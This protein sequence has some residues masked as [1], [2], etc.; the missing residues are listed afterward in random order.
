MKLDGKVALVTGAASGFGR[1]TSVLFAKEGAKVSVVDVNTAGGQE[2]VEMIKQSGGVAQFLSAD[3]S[4]ASDVEQMIKA[5]VDAYSRLDILVN[6]A[7][8]PML[9]TP[10]EDV[11]EQVW[12]RVIAV[13]LKG[14]FLGCK[15]GTPIM[16]KQGGGVIVNTASMSGVRPRAG[17]SAY[18]ASKGGVISL[19]KAV[20][21]QLAPFNIRVNSVSPVAADTP[22]LAGFRGGEVTEESKQAS[23]A[24]IPLGRLAKAEDIAYAILYLVSDEASMVTGFN[25]EVCGGRGI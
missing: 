4:K 8:I 9:N 7:G 12:D 20:A 19:T 14:V 3:V 13:N 6:N 22:M 23:G 11:E 10:I 16:K 18:V 2:T 24:A 21:L 25:L 15:Y 1:A 17:L 5:T